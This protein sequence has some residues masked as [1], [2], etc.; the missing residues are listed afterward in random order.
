MVS[1]DDLIRFFYVETE[2]AYFLSM[3]GIRKLKKIMRLER[4]M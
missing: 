4:Y 3:S 1:G 2:Q